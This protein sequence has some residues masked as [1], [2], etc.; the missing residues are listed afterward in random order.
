MP[1]PSAKSHHHLRRLCRKTKSETERGYTVGCAHKRLA[2]I[3]VPPLHLPPAHAPPQPRELFR[4]VW[5]THQCWKD[6]FPVQYAP[7]PPNLSACLAAFLSARGV[8]NVFLFRRERTHETA[9]HDSSGF[10]PC[11][12]FL[13]R[14]TSRRPYNYSWSTRV[15]SE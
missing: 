12:S 4:S 11:P 8:T 7:P 15:S 10:L 13:S 3:Y 14:T 9:H 1:F 2:F 6:S 5:D